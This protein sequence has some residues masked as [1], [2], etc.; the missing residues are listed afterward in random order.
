MTY[1]V[2]IKPSGYLL[3]VNE[4][5]TVLDAALRQGYEIPYSCGSA[6]CGTCMGKVLSGT[7]TYGN[8]EP[9]ALDANAKEENYALFCS[10]QPTSDLVI[11]L[12]DV[13][14]PEFLPVQKTEYQVVDS[15][16]LTDDIVQVFLKPEKKKLKYHAGQHL[17]VI[18]SDGSN[19]P[20]SIA[21]APNTPNANTPSQNE[22]IELHIKNVPNNNNIQD[23]LSK[24]ANKKTI[25]LRGP[26]GK[27]IYRTE[28]N[29]PLIFVAGGTGIVPLKA[30]IEEALQ[31]GDQRNIHLYWGGTNVAD[32]YCQEQFTALAAQHSNFKFIPVIT[33]QDNYW[34]GKTGLLLEVI[35]QEH[36]QFKDHLVYIS[37]PTEMVY[38]ARDKFIEKGLQPQL[39]F[40]DTFEYFPRD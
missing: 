10:V 12:E 21:N 11:E 8:V 40:S 16:N 36:T 22:H 24:V 19:L 31:Q 33:A 5:E 27:M 14:G 26:Y 9:Y 39:I 20:F 32:L 35:E 4:Q 29:F 15:K 2:K 28:P 37:G 6:T 18:G 30:M 34:Q 3:L 1:L 17:K 38:A 25:E 23:I 13:Y 7:Y